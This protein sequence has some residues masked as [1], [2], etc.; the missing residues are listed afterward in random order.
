MANVHGNYGFNANSVFEKLDKYLNKKGSDL[1]KLSAEQL[2][3]IFEA[4]E[5]NEDGS[6]NFNDFGV[7]LMEELTQQDVESLDVEFLELLEE[8]S[9]VDGEEL[10]ISADD[11]EIVGDLLTSYQKLEAAA[12]E[13][14]AEETAE[15]DEQ[16]SANAEGVKTTT[17]TSPDGTVTTTVEQPDGTVTVTTTAPDGTVTTVVTNGSDDKD[18]N[19]ENDTDAVPPEQTDDGKAVG[20]GN[21][22]AETTPTTSTHECDH[23]GGDGVVNEAECFTDDARIKEDKDGNKYI[24]VEAWKAEDGGNDCLSRIIEN[25]YDLEALGIEPYSEEYF[26]LE[27]AIMDANPEIYGDENGE[28]GRPLLEGHDG[29]R[30]SKIIHPGDK[31]VLPVYPETVDTVPSTGGT[32]SSSSPAPTA[33]A[34][35]SH[36]DAIG[37]EPQAPQTESTLTEEQVKLFANQLNNAA[38]R[39]GTNEEAFEQILKNENLN[40]A[41]FVK[42]MNAYGEI[43]DKSLIETIYDEFSGSTQNDYLK[44]LTESMAQ[45][46]G[47]G[48][49]EAIELLCKEIYAATEGK[50]GTNDEVLQYFF[51]SASDE[52]I[53]ALVEN[54][55]KYNEGSDL[56]TAL[57][58]DLN[59]ETYNK[60]VKRIN[61]AITNVN[62]NNGAEGVVGATPEQVPPTDEAQPENVP[63]EKEEAPSTEETKALT[64]DEAKE[65]VATLHDSFSKWGTDEE[66]VSAILDSS[67]YS[68]ADILLIM[69]TYQEAYGKSLIDE[70]QEDF[71]GDAEKGHVDTMV[72]A[73]LS[74]VENGSEK[75]IE[76]I[77]N[78]IYS[79]TEDRWGTYEYLL[80]SIFSNASNEAL[81][82]INENY[83]NYNEGT[84]LLTVLEKE[85]N[86]KLFEQYKKQIEEAM[87]A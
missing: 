37:G 25:C 28:G 14:K 46:A 86:D 20:N 67:K 21:S 85:L 42:I 6:I 44:L 26:A 69:D 48:S 61:D 76:M 60:Y 43:A 35:P 58:K 40:A 31:I 77:S 8:I 87:K 81:K 2:T 50:I 3:S 75:A 65:L 78:E 39:W 79:A 82:A 71:S 38:D 45:M 16:A 19:S 11:V 62:G 36:G 17:V 12:Q 10:K 33:E 57:D 23:C 1:D 7:E 56:L 80:E 64:P 24:E 9:A 72:K 68:S 13:P 15:G 32:T 34:E 47:E 59:D 83:S 41:D 18:V 84:D 30:H 29:E 55:S 27:K 53:L 63:E 70:I 73:M 22:T 54:Y 74:E 4:T 49:Q 52:A 51:D 5:K 66:A